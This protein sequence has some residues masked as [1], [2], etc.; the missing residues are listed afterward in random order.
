MPNLG[1]KSQQTLFERLGEARQ[2]RCPETV[3]SFYQ[4]Q[5]TRPDTA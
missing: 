4:N 2:Q 5:M 1:F 3:A